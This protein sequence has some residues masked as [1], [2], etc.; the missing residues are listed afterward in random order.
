MSISSSSSLSPDEVARHTFGTVRRGFDPGE[1]RAYLDHVA[2]ALRV[3][4]EREIELRHEVAEAEHRAANPVLDEGTLASALGQETARVL[5]SAHEAAHDMVANA[6]AEAAGLLTEAQEEIARS[7]ARAEQAL[8]ERTAQAEASVTEYR[9]RTH[10]ESE[11]MIAQARSE[12]REMI[13]E[14]QALRARIL[15]DL[16]KR[17]KVLHAQIEQLRAGREHLAE[18]VRGVRRTVD[19]IAAE[20][21]RAEDEAR[22]AAEAAG[23]EAIARP[24]QGTPEEEASALLAESAAEPGFADLEAAAEEE[25]P[26]VRD[27]PGAG[28]PLAPEQESFIAAEIGA[29]QIL[30]VPEQEAEAEGE[31]TDSR[32]QED[33]D[34]ILAQEDEGQIGGEP[35]DPAGDSAGVE[36]AAAP[37]PS[38]DELF[39]KLRAEQGDK[40]RGDDAGSEA[41]GGT[42]AAGPEAEEPTPGTP[43]VDRRDELVGPIITALSRRLKRTLQD[44]QND[45]LDRLRNNGS[46]WSVELLPDELEHLDAYT[47]AALPFLEQAAT[48]GR[49]FVGDESTGGPLTEHVVGVAADLAGAIV[50]PLRRRLADDGTGA[51]DESA[52]AERV[53]GAFREWKGERIERLAGDYVIAGFSAGS[54]AGS[55]Q[56]I[57]WIVAA[58][59]G[60]TPCPDCDDNAL[61]GPQPA[62]QE[63][64]TGHR[65]PPAHSGCRCLLAPSAT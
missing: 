63:F 29:S 58:A 43:L 31:G 62:G 13:E 40:G 4:A 8:A 2:D 44:D 47:T 61:N 41:E 12:C 16:S 19:G 1:V 9:Q 56:D 37:T 34:Q 57:E 6:E 55:S 11:A 38:V 42:S 24:Y 5:Q 30:A 20:L 39:A 14:A 33:E 65:H 23:R 46:S 60:A 52:V 51:A 36:T 48:A 35:V 53:G 17:R 3:A 27:Q 50:G 18:T 28:E 25:P 15:A 64:P 26:F 59:P 10:D 54:V 32:P 7:E 45:L 22:L 49:V 21:F